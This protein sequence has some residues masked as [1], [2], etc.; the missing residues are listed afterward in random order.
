[1]AAAVAN[2]TDRFIV[3]AVLLTDS[4]TTTSILQ[5]FVWDY[6]GESVPEET[7]SHSHLS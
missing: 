5:P 6:L 4:K 3:N 7:F 2:V 1:M